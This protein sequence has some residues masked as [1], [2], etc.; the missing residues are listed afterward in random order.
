MDKI[1]IS[2]V[3]A[4]ALIVGSL[5]VENHLLYLSTIF[6]HAG[7]DSWISIL[8][9]IIPM[10][11]FSYIVGTLAN[12]H[13]GKTFV[14][15]TCTVLGKWLGTFISILVI[16]FFLY[17][18]SSSLRGLSEFFTSGI[19]PRTPIVFYITSVTVL[20][21]YSL[22]KG[23]EVTARTT[24]IILPIATVIGILG[25]LFTMK[26][27]HFINLLPIMEF[28]PE[29]MLFGTYILIALYGKIFILTMIFPFTS[30][31]KRYIKYAIITF[32]ILVAM[33]IGPTIGPITI[34]GTDMTLK[35]T[36]PTYQQLRDINLGQLPR[37][38]MFGVILWGIGSYMKIALFHFATVIGLAQLFKLNDSKV[39]LAP[40]GALLIFF[41]STF[42]KD[43]M[44]FS[45]HLRN[46]EHFIAFFFAIVIPT[47]L[48]IVDWIRNKSISEK[49]SQTSNE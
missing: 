12:R 22:R 31:K 5:T 33:N 26:D 45:H 2:P 1:K 36:F 48:L 41:A 40:V 9:T 11:L 44:D 13:P 47:S 37:L 3:M 19:T 20:A 25:T 29:P 4:I 15:I 34:F 46:E 39:L 18:N 42:S 32:L 10:I 49:R 14:E 23:L 16:L 27:K 7:R 24:L 28:G 38:D 21:V 6:Y 8:A 17:D 35:L 43:F 30:G